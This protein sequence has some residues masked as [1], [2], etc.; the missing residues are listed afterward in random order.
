MN[1]KDALNY[2][3]VNRLNDTE[4]TNPFMLYCKLCDLCGA[5]FEDKHKV[6]L[7]YQ[8]DKRLNLTRAVLSKDTSV[9]KRYNEV[10]DLLGQMPFQKLVDTVR[11]AL[12]Y[13]YKRQPTTPKPQPKKQQNHHQKPQ[14]KQHKKVKPVVKKQPTNQQVTPTRTPLPNYNSGDNSLKIGVGVTV[15]V[16]ALI[17]LFVTL[18][19]VCSW[20]WNAWQW[21]IGIFGGLILSVISVAIVAISVTSTSRFYVLGSIMLGISLFVN[22][23]L[24]LIFGMNYKIILGCFL[25]FN[26]ICG[27][28][29]AIV[30]FTENQSTWVK[31]ISVEVV[32]NILFFILAMIFI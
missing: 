10:A 3:Y 13:N 17:A 31:I 29:L 19:I 30:T 8:V 16:L 1:F 28:M 11:I 4:L 20:P 7:F 18:G 21:I 24:A 2:I 32:A 5:S 15:G 27:A 23:T 6:T 25:V 14:P 12:S 9:I 26:I 22:L